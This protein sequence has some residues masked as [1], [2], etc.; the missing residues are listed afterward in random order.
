[1]KLYKIMVCIIALVIGVS[2]FT[3]SYMKF[4][5]EVKVKNN[6]EKEPRIVLLSHIYDNPY[7]QIIK[8][9]AEKAAKERGCHLEYNGPQAANIDENLRL[10]D[11]AVNAKADGILTYVQDEDPY[12]PHINNAIYSG[13][14]VI[15]IDS[16]AEKSM[17]YSYIGTDNVYA[18]RVA[19]SV[20]LEGVKGD[21]RIGIIIGGKVTNQLQ[22]VEGFKSYIENFTKAKIVDIES[23]DSYVVEA[24]IAAERMVRENPNINCL[25][26][27]SAL[28]GIGASDAV[29]DLKRNDIVI[30][31]FDNLP[32][33][34]ELIKRGEIYASIVQ[35]PYD[36]GYKGVNLMMDCI[37][38]KSIPKDKYLTEIKVI[39]KG[40]IE[41]YIKQK[42]VDKNEK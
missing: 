18:G 3:F 34:L 38:K 6:D 37:E 23:S 5:T 1:M 13:I 32:E 42:G 8:E 31:C 16:D 36:M 35:D 12:T 41:E 11:M 27:A 4:N 33:T 10:F 9:G 25:F 20:L 14:P 40:N 21:A 15:T 24:K 28:D 30:V 26:C 29:S 22:R 7:W 2:I 17:R 19:A 39:K